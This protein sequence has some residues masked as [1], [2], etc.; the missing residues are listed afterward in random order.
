M[1][2]VVGEA[3]IDLIDEGGRLDPHPG[4]GPFNTA[5]ALG[6]LG[7]P[8]GFLGR[9]SRDHFGELLASRLA[10]ANVDDRYILRGSAP[11]PLAMV[12]ETADGDHEFTFYLSGTAYADLHA[13]DLP[14]LDSG[15]V[16]ICAGTLAL[17]TDP[18]AAAVELLLEREAQRRVIVVDPN[19][20]PAVIADREVF[21]RRFERF[22]SF[23]HVV[24]LSDADA[25]WL[26]PDEGLEAIIE[27]ILQR[28]AQLAVLT[29]GAGGARASTHGAR[30]EVT[31]P[32]VDVVDTVG[33]GDAF[34]AGLLRWL[35][36]NGHLTPDAIGK[37]EAGELADGLGFA[38]I[39]GALQCAHAGATPP[40]LDQVEAF[41]CRPL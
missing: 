29:A 11:T 31:S 10:E 33:A 12:H 6:R 13:A 22:A 2:V 38:A 7:V 37:V 1:I 40:T 23:A 5:T 14:E 18:P 9:L 34:L 35:W 25:S 3:L 26:Y 20:R 15:V 28:G 41:A 21:R 24:K 17:A 32:A 36:L 30:C 39:V 4:G 8:V 27:K 19:V 16:A